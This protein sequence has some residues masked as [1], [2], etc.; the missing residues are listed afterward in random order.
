MEK[1]GFV[2]IW[3]DCYRK[4]FYI[5][6]HWGA[7]ND[8]YICSSSNMLKAYKRRPHDFK[9]KILKRIYTNKKDLLEEEHRWLSFI[10]D[11]ELKIKYYNLH[12][13]KFGHW[14]THDSNTKEDI[15]RRAREK[16]K[17]YWL[18]HPEE[19]KELKRKQKQYWLDHPEEYKELKRKQKESLSTEENLEKNRQQA[20]EFWNDPENRKAQS[21]RKK[22]FFK[23]HESN[24]KGA[25][26]SQETKE[27]NRKHLLECWQNPEFRE[28]QKKASNSEETKMKKSIAIK[29]ALK[30]KKELKE[31]NNG[32]F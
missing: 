7:E 18:D 22:E 30:R 31:V 26:A 16:Q 4:R 20:I 13:H 32:R 25:K 5:G 11:E 1:Y 27:R 28:K 10:K 8:G 21:E 2:Y 23:T 6:C 14:T 29:E 9:R 19:Y 12:N 17:Q 24:R 15:S 3:Y